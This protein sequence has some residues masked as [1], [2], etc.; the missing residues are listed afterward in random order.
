MDNF[1][2]LIGKRITRFYLNPKFYGNIGHEEIALQDFIYVASGTLF[3][4][5][6]NADFFCI[7]NI[8]STRTATNGI[9]LTNMNELIGQEFDYEKTPSALNRFCN[10]EIKN[11]K[12]FWNIERF[13]NSSIN[14]IYLESILLVF[15]SDLSL[16]IFCGEFERD[17]STNQ[18]ILIP[19]HPALLI[20]TDRNSFIKYNL[21]KTFEV[22]EIS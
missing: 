22:K 17:E 11:V 18:Y 2:K 10:E 6:E 14:E 3:I 12:Q 7:G 1:N 21:D 15:K 20:F 5:M 13:A 4:E 19:G 8:S 9:G 16:Y